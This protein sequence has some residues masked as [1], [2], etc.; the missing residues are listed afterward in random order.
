[1]DSLTWQE[2]PFRDPQPISHL[3]SFTPTLAEQVLSYHRSWPR[4][5]KTPLWRLEALALSLGVRHVWVKDES[6]R[7]GL[8]AFK[9]LG[10]TYAV[11]RCL[12]RE[13]GLEAV[14]PYPVLERLAQGRPPLTFATATDG[15]HGVGVAWAA[16]Q[17]RQQAH[18]YMPRGTTD[19]RLRAVTSAGGEV[20]TTDLDY[21]DLVA[22]VAQES[23]TQG[24]TLVQDTAWRGYD[25]IPTWIMQ[26]YLTLMAEEFLPS[27]GRLSP[28][29]VFLQAGV[30]SYA[31]AVAAFLANL[32]GPSI[33]RIVLIE[34]HS[35]ACFFRTAQTG[36]V[37][38]QTAPGP[39]RTVMAGLACGVGNPFAWDVLRRWVSVFVACDD[40]V[41][42]Q[43]MRILANP[44]GSDP[45]VISGESGAVGMGVLSSIAQDDRY[46][47]LRAA[48]DL[49]RNSRVLLISTEGATDPTNYHRIVREGFTPSIEF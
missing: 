44:L 36:A 13:L 28:T 7:W 4:Y 17:L 18:V 29:H 20:H 41:T 8:K 35:A 46:Y 31:A 40:A 38:L 1:M 14:P 21:D 34:P 19:A 15:N 27:E 25:E 39:I 37:A 26:G 32:M 45:A 47:H 24:W 23:R 12:A 22:W 42:A 49:N 30:G 33:P 10:G 6:Y 43:G 5:Q 11:G 9:G 16:S 48:L 2:N 3:A